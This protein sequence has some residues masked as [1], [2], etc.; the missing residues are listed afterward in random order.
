MTLQWDSSVH[1]L[2]LAFFPVQRSSPPV[3]GELF[4]HLWY[5]AG[6]KEAN[7]FQSVATTRAGGFYYLHFRPSTEARKDKKMVGL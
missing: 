4:C 6:E 5:P 2:S 1:S 7:P 3:E